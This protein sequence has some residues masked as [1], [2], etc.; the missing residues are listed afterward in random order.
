MIF[1]GIVVWRQGQGNARVAFRLNAMH[2]L[3]LIFPH[4]LFIL[5][6]PWEPVVTK[7]GTVHA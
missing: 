6:R 7:L 3:C 4:Q 2:F 5:K 1:P